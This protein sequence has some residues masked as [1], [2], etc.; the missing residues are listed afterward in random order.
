[1]WGRTDARAPFAFFARAVERGGT[2]RTAPAP[3]VALAARRH[4]P[5][6]IDAA[7]DGGS[8]AP[9]CSVIVPRD[10]DA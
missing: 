2:A 5:T 1:V 7:D 8:R 4:H 9:P 6:P 3:A 10:A